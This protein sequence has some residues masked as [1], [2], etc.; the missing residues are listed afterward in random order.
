MLPEP[1]RRAVFP[2]TGSPIAAP[3]PMSAK[4]SRSADVPGIA[5]TPRVEWNDIMTASSDRFPTDITGLPSAQSPAVIE[6]GDGDRFDLRIAPVAKRIG[7]AVVRM[8]A[9]NGSIPGPT[10]R[11]RQGSALLVNAV[12]NGDL[13]ATVHWHGLRVENRY[14][15]TAMTQQPMPVGGSFTYRLRFPDPGVYWYHPHIREDYGQEMGLYGN[16]VVVP[17]QP[18]YW[19]ADHRE[20]VVT[21]DD[22]LLEDGRV[23]A[24]SRSRPTYAAMGRFANTMLVNGENG[25]VLR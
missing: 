7:N 1:T 3:L 14:D 16:I 22:I 12:N 4:A 8:L 9:Y 2:G 18:D 6:P 24:F 21:L 19:P 11:V 20:L 23:A 15:G 10:L 13:E 17:A 5:V 25:L